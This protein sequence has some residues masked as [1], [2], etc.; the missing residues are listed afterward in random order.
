LWTDQV[1]ERVFAFSADDSSEVAH[2]TIWINGQNAEMLG[3][4]PD[5]ERDAAILDSFY[6][7]YPDA[8]G[9]VELRHVVDWGTDPFAGGSWADWSPGQISA[10]INVMS[11]PFQRLHFAG[12]HTA[13]ANPGMESA[14]ESGERAANEVIAALLPSRDVSVTERGELLFMRCQACHSAGQ[15]EPHKMGPNL[16]G[17]VDSQAAA[18]DDYAYSAAMQQADLHWDRQTLAAWIRHPGQLIPG[19]AMIYQNSLTGAEISEL[20]DYLVK[21]E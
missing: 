20:I 17:I 12:E 11:K 9:N 19:N 21:V 13:V 5:E 3:A 10:F 16:F 1:I 8:D 14:M 7:I 4:L 18:H 6:S 2:A 15:G